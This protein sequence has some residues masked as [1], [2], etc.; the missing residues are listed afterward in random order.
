MTQKILP[1]YSNAALDENIKVLNASYNAGLRRVEFTNRHNNAIEIFKAL[2][3]YCKDHL[4][5]MKLG[6]GTIM[7]TTDA[8]LFRAQGAAFLVSPLISQQLIDFTSTHGIEW[9]PGCATGAEIG[10]AQNAGIPLV[11]L[12]PIG[13]LG[14]T[15]FIKA[16]KGPFYKMKFQVSGGVKGEPEEVK[17]LLDA[18]ADIVGLGNSFF[19]NAMSEEEMTAKIKALLHSL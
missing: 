14:G 11:K 10:M 6:A 12:F 15:D 19:K 1:V 7:N 9:I 3:Q 16:M 17:A 2:M 5:G 13:S 18:G 4:P 8:A